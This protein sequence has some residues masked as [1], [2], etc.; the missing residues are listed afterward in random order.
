MPQVVTANRLHDGL[1]VFLTAD[2]AWSERIGDADAASDEP[3]AQALMVIAKLA[4]S[5]ARVVE[6]YLIDIEERD[7]RRR[8]SHQRESIRVCGPTVQVDLNRRAIGSAPVNDIG[9]IEEVDG[10]GIYAL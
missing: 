10:M 7:G 2:S 3:S 5:D 8:A 9:R 6:P 1:V 4:A